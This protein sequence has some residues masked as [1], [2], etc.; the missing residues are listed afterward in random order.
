MGGLQQGGAN[1]P[2]FEGELLD[3]VDNRRLHLIVMPTEACN[4]RCTYCY[5]AFA[6]G[7]MPPPVVEALKRFM[8]RRAPELDRLELGWFGGEPLLA[9]D[10]I[11][12]VML[13]AR[14]LAGAHPGLHLQ[15]EMTT[16]AYTLT[17]S[18][19]ERLVEL[20]ITMFQIS[21][22]GPKTWH[23]RKRRRP[24]GGA[25]YD[26][27][28]GNVLA[29]RGV[30]Q[31]FT[32]LLR[33]HID[34]ENCAASSVFVDEV[35]AA[36]A[37][38]ERFRLFLRP[39]SRFGGPNDP[40]LQPLEG[41]AGKG[42]LAALTEYAAQCGVPTYEPLESHRACYASYGN[43]FVVRSDGRLNKCTLALEHPR[44]QVG[45]LLPD[46]H[47]ELS[48]ELMAGWMRGVLTDDSAALRCPMRGFADPEPGTTPARRCGPP[49]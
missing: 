11:D 46:G 38:D 9:R 8:T 37:G 6:H 10:V 3:M 47:V 4:L 2:R 35:Q 36:F 16:N 19:F 45:R 17:R 18:V 21:F 7:R 20:G 24:D 30:Q 44:N 23:D 28:W 27:I 15:A 12:R 22:D 49:S 42:S 32:I 14:T 25:T 34:R 33:L 48:N 1:M 5:E 39:L 26:R 40:G 13:H 41:E 43:S 31:E 29:M